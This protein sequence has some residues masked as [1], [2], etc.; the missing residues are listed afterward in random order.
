MMETVKSIAAIAA[1]IAIVVAVAKFVFAGGDLTY[2]SPIGKIAFQSKGGG[3]EIQ[4]AGLEGHARAGSNNTVWE[5]DCPAKSKPISG[6]CIV[7]EAPGPAPLQNIGPNI[8]GGANRWEC[9]WQAPVTKASVRAVCVR[10]E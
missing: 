5:S 4:F 7:H 8:G 10:T 1:A 9:A 2:E 6:T 3:S